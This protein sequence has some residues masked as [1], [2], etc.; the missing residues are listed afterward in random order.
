LRKTG[1]TILTYGSSGHIHIGTDGW[2]SGRT[3]MAHRHPT[4]VRT[5]SRHR[6]KTRAA[7]KQRAGVRAASTQRAGVRFAQR[8]RRDAQNDAS[9]GYWSEW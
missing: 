7:Y 8:Q 1:Y 6:A 9:N 2:G 5:A 3:R 4:R